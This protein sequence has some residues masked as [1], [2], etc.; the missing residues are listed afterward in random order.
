M[1]YYEMGICT[2]EDERDLLCTL[3]ENTLSIGW[4]NTPGVKSFDFTP[5]DIGWGKP[6]QNWPK[7]VTF[8]YEKKEGYWVP[9]YFFSIPDFLL[10]SERLVD[11]LKRCETE[12]QLLDVTLLDTN[13]GERDESYKIVNVINVIDV[14][15]WEASNY[16]KFPVNPDD[17][18][19]DRIYLMMIKPVF[20]KSELERIRPMIF[21]TKEEEVSVYVSEEYKSYCEQEKL[22][23]FEF[24]EVKQV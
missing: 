3:D 12:I 17:D 24:Y 19:D 23:G 5:S 4:N 14:I 13:T 15:S 18:A 1:K 22:T 16:K 7:G 6:V 2:S 11:G 20:K 9:D 10:F 21:K 8:L